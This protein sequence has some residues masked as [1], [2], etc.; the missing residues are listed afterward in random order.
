MV[1]AVVV[2]VSVTICVTELMLVAV[3]N[4]VSVGVTVLYIALVG[5]AR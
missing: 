1:T 5:R 3:T 2:V 4:E